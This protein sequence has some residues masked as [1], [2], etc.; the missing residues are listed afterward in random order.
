MEK[1]IILVTGAN[2][3]IGFEIA[4]QLALMEQTVIISARNE[5]KGKEA[6]DKLTA[7]KLSA[8]FIKLDVTDASQRAEAFKKVKDLYGRLDVLIN[9]AGISVRS[10]NTLTKTDDNTWSEI[11]STNAVAPLKLS[12]LFAPLMQKGSRII[13]I[14][15]GGG[16]MTDPVGGWSP[17]YCISKTTLNAITRHL[18]FYLAPSGI[19]V[20]AVCPGWVKTDMGG[21]NA[22]LTVEQGADTA[23]WIATTEENIPSGKFWRNRK[24]IPW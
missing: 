19:S 12:Q 23:V 13:N 6:V 2:K 21:R 24:V 11:M 14:S 3:G 7:G 16:S 9:N 10:D 5:T 17:V 20:N 8:T 15:S 22:N 4:R 18:S 1:K